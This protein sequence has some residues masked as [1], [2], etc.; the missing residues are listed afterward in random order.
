MRERRTDPF[1]FMAIMGAALCVLWPFSVDAGPRRSG[2]SFGSPLMHEDKPESPP[3]G[4]EGQPPASQEGATPE[5][6]GSVPAFLTAPIPEIPGPKRTVSVGKFDAIGAFTS[7]YGNWDIGGGLSAM[8]TSALV[9]SQRFIVLER[10]NIGQILSEQ[11][12]KASGIINPE[13]G[14][15]VGNVTGAQL[16][17]YGAVTE[18]GDEDTGG[19]FSLGAGGVGGGVGRLLSGALSTQSAQGV[20][21]IDIR[22]VDTTTG[23]VMKTHRVK[24]VIMSSGFDF[25]LGYSGISLG[26]NQFAKTPLGQA[27]REAITEVVQRI[28]IDARG[29]TWTGRV[30]EVDGKEVYINAGERSGL[31]VGDLFMIERIVKKLTDPETGELLKI[32][33]QELGVLRLTSVEDKISY[34]TY[35]PLEQDPPTRGDLVAIMR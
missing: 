23:Q 12:M 2:A 19:G 30:V 11:E 35:Q 17:I 9:E 10:A 4:T 18:F 31:N 27:T 22:V 13:T 1:K 20:V 16:L 33:K 21:A 15:R 34:G 32:R 28:A 6:V 25:S 3:A 24:K 26:T 29:T 8:M 5:G 14:P 7:K